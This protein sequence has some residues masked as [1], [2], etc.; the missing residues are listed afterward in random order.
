MV[1]F[2]KNNILLQII[3]L[4]RYSIAEINKNMAEHFRLSLIVKNRFLN[5]FAL[6]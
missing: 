5:Q 4:G 6:L 2:L 3:A 1:L